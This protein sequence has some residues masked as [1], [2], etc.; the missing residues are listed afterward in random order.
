LKK[1]KNFNNQENTQSLAYI[2]NDREH[3]HDFD[4]FD[5]PVKDRV[6]EESSQDEVEQYRLL[7]QSSANQEVDK[8]LDP[9][10]VVSPEKNSLDWWR[11]NKY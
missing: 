11:E 6:T 9:M 5:S 4:I 2:S 7:F 3:M 8:Y 10:I 1:L